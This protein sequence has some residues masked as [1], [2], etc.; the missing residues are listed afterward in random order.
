[1][2]ACTASLIDLSSSVSSAVLMTVTVSDVMED[3]ESFLG[4]LVLES[5]VE[6]GGVTMST[7]DS[8][9]T[10]SGDDS[11][12]LMLL[13]E[14]TMGPFL[15]VSGCESFRWNL[16]ASLG[17]PCGEDDIVLSLR[18]AFLPILGNVC[19]RDCSMRCIG[20]SGAGRLGNGIPAGDVNDRARGEVDFTPAPPGVELGGNR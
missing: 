3:S 18:L 10:S 11:P 9:L 13:G 5:V 6:V 7:A 4:V 12:M 1:M 17:R 14:S 15:L 8:F 2:D 16:E 19:A 20:G